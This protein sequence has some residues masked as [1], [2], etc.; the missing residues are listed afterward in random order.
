MSIQDYSIQ[1]LKKELKRKIELRDNAPKS[2]EIVD[3]KFIVRRYKGEF[4]GFITRGM[5][6]SNPIRIKAISFI[7][8]IL[9]VD[10]GK[11]VFNNGV[12]SQRQ[13]ENRIKW[14][15]TIS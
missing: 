5:K 12:E 6:P 9:D 10:Y 1:E 7:G 15:N 4:I 3:G 11:A 2:I 13:L 8:V 14:E